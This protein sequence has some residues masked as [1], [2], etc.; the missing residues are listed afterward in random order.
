M[1]PDDSI[2]Q[3][4]NLTVIRCGTNKIISSQPISLSM[5]RHMRTLQPDLVQFNAPNFWAGA[6]LILARHKGPLIVTHHADVFGRPF[7]KRAVMPIYHRLI[8]NATC[9]VINSLKNASAS[10]DLPVGAG[11]FVA[12]PHGVDPDTYNI[13]DEGR[14]TLMAERR[15]QFGD[16]PVVGFVGRFVRYKGLSVLI[17]AAARLD[18]VHF[19]MIGDGPLRQQ[20]EEQARAAGI[21]HRVHFLGNLDETAKVRSIAMMDALLLPS[22]DTTEA[23][24]VVQIEAQLMSV[25]VIA[26]SLPTGVTDVT[27]DN[28]TGLLV[29]PRDPEA[30]AEAISRLIGDRDLAARLG[31]AG[32]AHAL[33]NFTFGVFQQRFAELFDVILAGQPIDGLVSAFTLPTRPDSRLRNDGRA[34]PIPDIKST[35]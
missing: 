16:A 5:L 31:R 28:E 1:E 2:E 20:T 32:R 35:R 8:R 27:L 30:L 4:A 6:M 26:S 18:G 10:N 3:T 13:G 19:L 17:D 33:K 9:V 7:L 21:V 22:V 15:R 24:G 29:P 25:P 11:P 34:A 23:F 14:R 12:I